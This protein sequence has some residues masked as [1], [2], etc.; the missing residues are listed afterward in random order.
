M[1]NR[2]HLST[3]PEKAVADLVTMEARGASCHDLRMPLI[4]V[5]PKSLTGAN[6]LELHVTSDG[7]FDREQQGQVGYIR[8][9]AH[10][11]D[12]AEHLRERHGLGGCERVENLFIDFADPTAH[13]IGAWTL[14][15]W[16]GLAEPQISAF[17]MRLNGGGWA[18]VVDGTPA[19]IWTCE[20]DEA[21][22][23]SGTTDRAWTS[24][25]ELAFAAHLDAA[26]RSWFADPRT[27]SSPTPRTPREA[28]A[29]ALAAL[30]TA[31]AP[32]AGYDRKSRIRMAAESRGEAPAE[33][34]A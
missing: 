11:R 32:G 5:V 29:I 31:H 10:P 4:Y 15:R 9:G 16:L 28:L 7:T 26:E 1:S 13:L 6:G 12:L 33:R 34:T 23:L 25:R 8:E 27:A 30:I 2:I 3:I 17:V 21:A 19:A 14:A 22:F 18:L 20:H 24:D